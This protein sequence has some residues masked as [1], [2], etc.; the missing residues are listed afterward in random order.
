MCQLKKE[1]FR[2][3]KKLKSRKTLRHRCTCLCED[4]KPK[5]HKAALHF[6]Q[7]GFE[8]IPDLSDKNKSAFFFPKCVPVW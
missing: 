2:G 6:S 1:Y 5:L 8:S 3:F 7:K 4:V